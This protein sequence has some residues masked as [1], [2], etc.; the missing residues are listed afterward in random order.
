MRRDGRIG[1]RRIPISELHRYLWRRVDDRNRIE[2]HIPDAAA[3]L[4]LHYDTVTLHR[5]RLM[6]QGLIHKVK[7][8]EFGHGV[9]EVSC[10]EG[11]EAD[12]GIDRQE[13]EVP[14]RVLQWS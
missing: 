6:K 14:A 9:F 5:D 13:P 1:W 2:L 7:V 4:D 11:A 3:A 10:P 8:V 12:R